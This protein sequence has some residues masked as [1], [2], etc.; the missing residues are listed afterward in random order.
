MDRR[1]RSGGTKLSGL[2]RPAFEH[3]MAPHGVPYH[4]VGPRSLQPPA[5]AGQIPDGLSVRMW[6]G[7]ETGFIDL[8]ANPLLQRPTQDIADGTGESDLV[9]PHPH[10]IRDA[11]HHRVTQDS[12]GE[13]PLA[14]LVGQ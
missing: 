13:V 5:R 1:R 8:S 2:W 7:R 9:P 6:V 12:L 4:V 14:A 10:G 11:A 3:P